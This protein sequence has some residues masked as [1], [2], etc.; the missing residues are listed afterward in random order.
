M[1]SWGY[2]FAIQPLTIVRI[3][4]L[5]LSSGLFFPVSCTT[6]TYI[7]THILSHLHARDVANGETPYSFFHVLAHRPVTSATVSV[8]HLAELD[9]FIQHDETYSFLMQELEGEIKEGDFVLYNYHVTQLDDEK[10]MI[11]VNLVGDD[12]GATSRYIAE[13]TQIRPQYSR[14]FS[15]GHMIG[16]L[17]YA[18]GFTFILWLTGKYLLRR[19]NT[20]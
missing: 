18:I 1:G 3:V 10:Q 13:R 9:Q 19:T 11:E 17:P 4:G 8:L 12:T 15:I 16:S 14:I 20:A 5:V 6:A 7:G 2:E